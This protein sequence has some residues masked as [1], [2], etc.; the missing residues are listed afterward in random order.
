[1]KFPRFFR[2]RYNTRQLLNAFTHEILSVLDLQEL[3]EVTVADLIRIMKLESAGILLHNR[4]GKEYVLAASHG[5]KNRDI[6][7][8]EQDPLISYLGTSRRPILLDK[9][10]LKLKEPSPL[11]GSFD[12]L[13]A[14]LCLP[15]QLHDQLIG[16]LFLGRK[17]SGQDYTP[18]DLDVL[19]A[20]SQTEAIAISNAQLFNELSKMQTEIVQRE[21]M[22]V[23]GTLAA[24]I[25]HE[26]CNPLSIIRGECEIFLLNYRDNHY[27]DKSQEEMLGMFLETMKKVVRETDRAAAITKRLSSFAKPS[28]RMVQ[29][30]VEIEKEINEVLGLMTHDL[31]NKNI[32][33]RMQF[34]EDFP[35][36]LADR[37]QLDEILFNVLRNC[38]QL[39]DKPEAWISITGTVEDEF[40]VVCIEDN[41]RGMPAD[42]IE[43]IFNP[44]Y[45]SK[46]ADKTTDLGLFI[47]KQ[48]MEQQ[49][50]SIAVQSEEGAGSIFVLRFPAQKP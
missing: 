17:R 13:N 14:T 5:T 44:F 28:G 40:A 30:P 20:L 26:I 39:S 12:K 27:K 18:E 1:M 15:L 38:V 49:K 24:G 36:I 8:S 31:T 48:I 2:K 42:K 16:V 34:S 33:I 45:V 29:E 25:N 41:G 46:G 9:K 35:A 23:I 22:A 43:N 50:G 32:E 7:F 37:K 4:Q 11:K 21:K 6:R 3:M 19:G 10:A 47:V